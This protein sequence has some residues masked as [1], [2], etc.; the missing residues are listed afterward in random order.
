MSLDTA[1]AAAEAFM[2][3]MTQRPR[4][5]PGPHTL[6]V[7]EPGEL[8]LPFGR[9]IPDYLKNPAPLVAMIKEYWSKQGHDVSVTL[10]PFAG[11]GGGIAIRSNLG[12]RG[13]P[14]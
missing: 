9:K 14:L 10:H 5:E 1:T 11:G 7:D 3:E 2:A 13:L 4:H 6:A 12:P 8:R